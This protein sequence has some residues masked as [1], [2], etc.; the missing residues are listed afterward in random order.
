MAAKGVQTS[1]QYSSF[2][3]SR[4]NVNGEE[5]GDLERRPIRIAGLCMGQQSTG[6]VPLW[7]HDV[8]VVTAGKYLCLAAVSYEACDLY[9]L[10]YNDIQL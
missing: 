1:C 8:V 2:L 3:L 6:G 4:F 10:T 9:S 7:K 5:L